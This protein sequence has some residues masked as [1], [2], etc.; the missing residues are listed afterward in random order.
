MNIV[1]L[2]P[3]IP[4]PTSTGL[5]AELLPLCKELVSLGNTVSILFTDF[6]GKGKFTEVITD[7]N[8]EVQNHIYDSAPRLRLN[9]DLREAISIFLYDAEGLFIPPI[10]HISDILLSLREIDFSHLNCDAIVSFK[11]WFRTAIPALKTSKQLDI[12]CILWLDDYDISIHS[13]FLS[14]FSGIV[15]L[16]SYIQRLYSKFLP[17]C[18]PYPVESEIIAAQPSSIRRD[19][20]KSRNLLVSFPG[21]GYSKKETLAIMEPIFSGFPGIN[22]FLINSPFDARQQL[23]DF[24][25]GNCTTGVLRFI[26]NVPRSDY[27]RLLDKQDIA[28]V[29]QP[30]NKYGKAKTS[31]RLL[32]CMAKGIPVISPDLGGASETIKSANCGLLTEPDDVESY[33]LRLVE[34]IDNPQFSE[35]L[36]RNGI[37]YM[38]QR[39]WKANALIFLDYVTTLRQLQ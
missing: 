1:F 28:I 27:L 21:T 7:K 16:T 15:T 9:H 20:S 22:K 23:I 39:S 5:N 18:L 24:Q 17:F 13:H 33:A 2:Y 32:E 35:D 8:Y 34:L 29:L 38:R 31:I 37:E 12:P 6:N 26:D 30:N 36:G 4:S 3:F 11:P 10:F 25:R 19:S 14:K